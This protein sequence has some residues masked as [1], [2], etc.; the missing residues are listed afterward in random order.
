M[1]PLIQSLGPQRIKSRKLRGAKE[2]GKRLVVI[3]PKAV[4]NEDKQLDIKERDKKQAFRK[5]SQN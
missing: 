2:K 3:T 5:G 1:S 4:G